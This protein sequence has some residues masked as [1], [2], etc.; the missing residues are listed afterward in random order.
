MTTLS[1]TLTATS[2]QTR[3]WTRAEVQGYRARGGDEGIYNNPS[4]ESSTF[5]ETETD[6]WLRYR[7]REGNYI[8]VV[9]R[10]TGDLYWNEEMVVV[11]IKC[12]G[13]AFLIFPYT[14]GMMVTHLSLAGRAIVKLDPK[15]ALK[16][17]FK[18]LKDPFFG[19]IFFL[20]ALYGCASP[21]EGRKAIAGIE[22]EWHERTSYRDDYLHNGDDFHGKVA[23]LAWCFQ[24]R[25]NLR[26]VTVVAERPCQWFQSSM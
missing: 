21:Y 11:A 14:V 23:Y 16:Q 20:S 22:Y 5:S 8:F 15:E 18:V 24:V 19:A 13:L 17:F 6:R 10:E 1:A 25:G 2:V 4:S 12:F 3:P 9:E 26:D 7:T